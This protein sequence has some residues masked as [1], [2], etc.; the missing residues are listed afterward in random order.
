[1]GH[2][3]KGVCGTQSRHHDDECSVL[4]SMLL[5]LP[6]I[7]EHSVGPQAREWAVACSCAATDPKPRTAAN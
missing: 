2:F 1:M 4:I 7:Q 3:F 5:L 6:I